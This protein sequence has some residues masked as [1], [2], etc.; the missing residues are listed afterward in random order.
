M[1]SYYYSNDV[2]I[3]IHGIY[4][5]Q[6]EDEMW[7]SSSSDYNDYGYMMDVD[8]ESDDP[9][10]DGYTSNDS[11]EDDEDSDNSAEEDGDGD[12]SAKEDD[13]GDNSVKD[14]SHCSKSS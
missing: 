2:R 3:L 5:L 7:H 11:S 14:M 12:N 1:F 10:E 13:D 6:A 9:V 4:F 8:L